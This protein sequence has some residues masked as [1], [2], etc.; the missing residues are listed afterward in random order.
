MVVVVAVGLRWQWFSKRE[1]RKIG[2]DDGVNEEEGVKRKV[3]ER[4]LNIDTG[5]NACLLLILILDMES[6][7][8]PGLTECEHFT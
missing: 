7:T 5:F 2:E 1:V 8:S 6:L 3:R 4:L